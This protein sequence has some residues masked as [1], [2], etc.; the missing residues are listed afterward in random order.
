ML[1]CSLN[2]VKRGEVRMVR[3]RGKEV[4]EKRG[5]GAKQAQ[6]LKVFIAV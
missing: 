5:R 4:P 3:K 2:R 6:V 1:K